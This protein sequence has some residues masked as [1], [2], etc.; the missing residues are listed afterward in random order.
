MLS[1]LL[2]LLTED[3]NF[4]SQKKI[5]AGHMGKPLKEGSVA[6]NFSQAPRFRLV[7]TL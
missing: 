6:R 4:Q 3:L 2:N 1:D 5:Y 7:L